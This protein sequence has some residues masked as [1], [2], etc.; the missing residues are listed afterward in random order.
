MN[1]NAQEID[2]LNEFLRGEISAIET[3]GQA[4]DKAEAPDE[5]RLLRENRAS[6]EERVQSL[7]QRIQSLGGTPSNDSGAWGTW[8]KLLEGGAKLFGT[9]AALN[10]L[11]EGEDHGCKTYEG[12]FPDFSPNFRNYVRTELAIPQRKTHDVL[13]AKVSSR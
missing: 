13:S 4:M 9:S 10:L 2:Q 8:A 6:H 12:Q 11:E 3:Y 1:T 5:L 7:K